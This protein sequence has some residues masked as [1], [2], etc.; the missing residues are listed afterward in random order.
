MPEREDDDEDCD[1]MSGGGPGLKPEGPWFERRGRVGALPN[2]D[3]WVE[4]MDSSVR[5][6]RLSRF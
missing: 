5:L 1:M 3:D 4:G 2:S 6:D